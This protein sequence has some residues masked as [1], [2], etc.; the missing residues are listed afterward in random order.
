MSAQRRLQGGSELL[1]CLLYDEAVVPAKPRIDHDRLLIEAGDATTENMS[2]SASTSDGVLWCQ[3][4]AKAG[5]SPIAPPN[6]FS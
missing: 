1:D 4:R 3:G 2:R 6:A 5:I